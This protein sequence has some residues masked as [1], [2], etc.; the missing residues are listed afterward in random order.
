MGLRRW[1]AGCA[2]QYQQK[3]DSSSTF[4]EAEVGQSETVEK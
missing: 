4:A 1:L 2:V 3:M